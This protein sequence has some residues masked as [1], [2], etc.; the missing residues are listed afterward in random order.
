MTQMIKGSTKV[1]SD[2]D[3]HS[4]NPPLWQLLAPSIN[5]SK[6]PGLVSELKMVFSLFPTL[7]ISSNIFSSEMVSCSNLLVRK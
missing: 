4:L 1:S 5:F 2:C 6:D 3:F 7:H